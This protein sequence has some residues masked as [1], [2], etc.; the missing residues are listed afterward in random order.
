[1]KQEEL[2]SILRLHKAWLN[3]KEFGE[4]ADLQG[5]ILRGTDLRNSDLQDVILRGAILEDSD[6]QGAILRKIDLRQSD[7]RHSDLRGAI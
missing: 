2:N 6:L 5:E 1:M 7:L 3:G 4:R